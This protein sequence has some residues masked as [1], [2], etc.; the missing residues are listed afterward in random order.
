MSSNRIPSNSTVNSSGG[1]DRMEVDSEPQS[2]NSSLTAPSIH[3][4]PQALVDRARRI[5]LLQ[6]RLENLHLDAQRQLNDQPK[7]TQLDLTTQTGAI[8]TPYGKHG[9][10]V[11]LSHSI[12][13]FL[14]SDHNTSHLT[15]W[16]ASTAALQQ[17]AANQKIQHA[18]LALADRVVSNA[19]KHGVPLDPLSPTSPTVAPTSTQLDRLRYLALTASPID[20]HRTTTTDP[21]TTSL[22]RTWPFNP[23]DLTLT[24][25]PYLDLP[26]TLLPTISR[27]LDLYNAQAN[28]HLSH[29]VAKYITLATDPSRTEHAYPLLRL[30][31]LEYYTELVEGLFDTEHTNVM[32]LSQEQSGLLRELYEKVGSRALTEREKGLVARMLRVEVGDV[33]EWWAMQ[34]RRLRA[35]KGSKVWLRARE[36]EAWRLAG[37]MGVL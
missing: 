21:E 14:S 11:L 12:S 20:G 2:R 4:A 26:A 23:A 28:S 31:L 18:R 29:H 34:G 8:F 6:D 3:E 22:I 1:E 30:G 37:K 25:P 24:L 13:K 32:E 15:I 17:A 7:S 16:S 19:A 27:I 36:L 9:S 33:E 5:A 10:Q 35:W